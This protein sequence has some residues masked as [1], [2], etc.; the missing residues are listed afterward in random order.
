MTLPT[1]GQPERLRPPA[2]APA[3]SIR[4]RGYTPFPT[5]CFPTRIRLGPATSPGGLRMNILIIGNGGREHALAWKIAQSPRAER[6][7][8]APGNAGTDIDG[9]NVD[10]HADRFPGPDPLRQGKRGGADGGRARGP[11]GRRHRRCLRGRPGCGSSVPAR[12]PPNWR[13]ARSS[14]RTCSATPTSPRPTTRPSPIADDAIKFLKDREDVP[15]VVKADGLAAGKGVVVCSGRDEAIAGRRADRPA[16]GLRRGR[17]P[18]G[19]R[20]AA[21]RPGGQRAGDHRRPDDRHPAAGPGPQGGLRRRHRPEHRR[22]GRLLPG[23]AGRRRD[24]RTGS[25]ST[26]WC[27]R[28]T[29]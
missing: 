6:V 25:R 2:E 29:P 22:H 19:D 21:R 10:I 27:P 5:A 12:P 7:F 15:V 3:A 4:E 1:A 23:P 20:G 26:S 14:A 9:E 8:V 17:R 18:A 16:K 13:P 11:A 24:A 28:S